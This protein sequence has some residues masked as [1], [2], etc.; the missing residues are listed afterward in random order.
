[1][2][3]AK[4]SVS[5]DGV[6]LHQSFFISSS[7]HFRHAKLRWIRVDIDQNLD[8]KLSGHRSQIICFNYFIFSCLSNH[9]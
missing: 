9:R 4:P 3:Q 5:E 6:G 7:C 2:G 1:M 8:L